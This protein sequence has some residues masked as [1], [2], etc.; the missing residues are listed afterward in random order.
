MFA[1]GL[2]GWYTTVRQAREMSGMITGLGQ[3]GTHMPNRMAWPAFMAMWL[4]MMVAMMLPTIGPVVLAQRMAAGARSEGVL[5]S[6]GFVASYLVVW[7]VIGLVPLLAFLAFGNQ[8]MAAKSA[9]WLPMVGGAGLVVA[10]VYQVTPW[11]GACLRACRS[12]IGF[13]TKHNAAGAGSTLRAGASYGANCVGSCWALMAVLVVVGLMNLVWMAAIALVFLAE[14]NWRHGVVLTRVDG[15]GVAALG[16]A[17]AVVP[18]LL[19]AIS[20]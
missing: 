10:G 5:V 13:V 16:V 1:L 4:G 6:V 7:L 18:S 2:L 8:P 19:S 11:K 17:V 15:G 12:P 9:P 14:K 3:V 20:S